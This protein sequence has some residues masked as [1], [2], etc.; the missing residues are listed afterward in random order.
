M[1]DQEN[2][3][4]YEILELTPDASPQDIRAAY[5]RAKA[6]YKKDSPALY[7]LI[8]PDE[9]EE[10]LRKIEEAY[11]VLSS[12]E[13]RKEYD[14]HFGVLTVEYAKVVSI[15][16]VPPMES[17]ADADLL[18]PPSTD[19]TQGTSATQKTAVASSSPFDDQDDPFA[20]PKTPTPPAAPPAAKE[21]KGGFD[22][23]F[24]MQSS[25]PSSDPAFAP[26]PAPAPPPASYP[27]QTPID[28]SRT[29]VYQQQS[30]NT[31]AASA[32]DDPALAQ[33]IAEQVD[34]RGMFL[35]KVREKRTISIEEMCDYT[36][37][38]KTYLFAI[39]EE[40]YEKLPAPV[41][42]RGFVTQIAKYLRLPHEKVAAAYL[43][44]HALWRQEK[45][46]SKR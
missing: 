33:E 3:T 40:N 4:Y 9:T 25:P 11:Q 41:Y 12:P 43:G 32:M 28:H 23:L 46:K 20:L 1:I 10:L 16:R 30:S 15:D 42:L 37:I 22:P 19:F 36:K 21:N 29:S 44:R 6:A 31:R 18:V 45:E 14:R 27:S 2:Q 13:R 7:S 26:A 38:T 17:G 24:G 39:E 35:R 5:L 34:W 8:T